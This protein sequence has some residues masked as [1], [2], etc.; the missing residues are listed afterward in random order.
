MSNPGRILKGALLYSLEEGV[1]KTSK[2]KR[3]S[4][5]EILSSKNIF[6]SHIYEVRSRTRIVGIKNTTY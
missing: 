2:E 1:G 5:K 3:G 6:D 4:F